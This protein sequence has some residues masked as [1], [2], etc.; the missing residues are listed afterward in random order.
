MRLLHISCSLLVLTF[1][2]R[3]LAQNKMPIPPGFTPPAVT[4][5]PPPSSVQAQSTSTVSDPQAVA[6]VQAAITAIG[7]ATAIGALQSWTFKAQATGRIA[8]G[9]I[10][11]ILA[12]SI[13][14]NSNQPAG[15]TAKA[16]PP[17]AQP[18]SLF[19]PALVS[20]IL[21]G[22]SQDTRFSAKQ[23]LASTAVPNST[24]VVF[25][26]LTKAGESL[27]AQ[28]WYFDNTTKL[29]TRIDFTL[30]ARFGLIETFPG[31][32]ILSDFRTIGGIL[33]PFKIVTF[34]Q[35]ERAVQTITLQSLTPSTTLPSTGS[36]GGAQ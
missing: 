5:P 7:G 22:E 32:V 28:K 30:P 12:T 31:T 15:T 35:R 21:A 27:P 20:A 10:T 11:E 29:P 26:M 34:L 18:R 16:P 1:A 9:P 19:L 2:V 4:T 8:N 6:V 23:G 24:V 33:Y 36:T 25:S 14:Q 3:L 17:W 13:P